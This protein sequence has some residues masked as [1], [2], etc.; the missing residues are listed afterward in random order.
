MALLLMAGCDQ[1]LSDVEPKSFRE[2]ELFADEVYMYNASMPDTRIRFDPLINDSIRTTVRVSYSRP[3]NG[4]L[5][6]MQDGGT[7]YIP[8]KGFFGTE[9]ITYTACSDRTCQSQRM[10]IF[11]EPPLDPNN[12]TTRLGADSLE[13][14]INTTKGIRIFINDM[15]CSPQRTGIS[16]FKPLKGTFTTVAYSGSL[17]NTIYLYTPPRNFTGEDSF[18]YRVHPDPD[19]FDRVYLEMVVKITV[20]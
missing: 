3:A 5:E 7:Y 11:V 17:K 14:A 8:N 4:Q 20:K 13:T 12:C 15:I 10:Q 9:D 2:F 19:N 16:V 6:L 1:T 18:R